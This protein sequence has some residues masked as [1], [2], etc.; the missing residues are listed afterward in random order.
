MRFWDPTA[1]MEPRALVPLARLLAGKITPQRPRILL[2][3]AWHK[4]GSHWQRGILEW[5][6]AAGDWNDIFELER[7]QVDDGERAV[8]LR[9][10]RAFSG[11]RVIDLGDDISTIADTHKLSIVGTFHFRPRHLHEAFHHFIARQRSVP[12]LGNELQ[13]VRPC[14]VA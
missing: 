5:L 4:V 12:A 1:F 2:Q 14:H 10:R 7:F 6:F 11:P 3:D 13:V 9:P 8:N